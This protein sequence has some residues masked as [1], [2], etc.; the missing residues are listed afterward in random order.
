LAYAQPKD[1]WWRRFTDAPLNFL[2]AAPGLQGRRLLDV[3]CGLGYLVARAG[4]RG[5]EASGLDCSPAAVAVGRERLGLTLT[6]ARIE[7]GTV[8]PASQDIVVL[9]HVL[10]H[11]PDP[12]MAVR[13]V[14]EWLR[15]GGWLLAGTPNF[16]SPIARWSGQDWAGLV[17]AQHM[18]H[19]TPASLRRLTAEGG[20]ARVLW[21]TRMLAFSP[22]RATD[23]AKWGVRRLLEPLRLADNLLLLTQR[24]E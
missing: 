4:E 21:T 23:W 15:P 17:P 11:L 6:C 22:G 3:G 5:F 12:G 8:D 1:R 18:W 24:P 16:A 9:N 7:D 19:F 14:W 20:F 13:R 2:E 10:E